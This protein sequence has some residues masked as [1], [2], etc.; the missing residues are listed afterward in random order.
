MPD[1]E[2]Y[3]ICFLLTDKILNFGAVSCAR[4]YNMK[5]NKDLTAI[6]KGYGI[7]FVALHNFLHLSLFAD[8]VQENE[9]TYDIQR[10]WDYL[11]VLRSFEWSDIGQFFSFLGWIGVA[12]FIF[13]SGYGLVKKYETTGEEFSIKN[14]VFHSW[15][16][17]AVLLFLPQLIYIIFSLYNGTWQAYIPQGILQQALL[18]NLFTPF[19]GVYPG[20][21][22]YFG[23]AFEMY[24]LYCVVRKCNV[25]QLFV[26]SL[27]MLLLQAVTVMIWGPVSGVWSWVRHNFIGWGQVFLAGMILAKS[28]SEKY[29]PGK[30]WVAWIIAALSLASLPFLLLNGWTWLLIVPY[31]ALLFFL[32]LTVAV[33]KTFVLKRVGLWL[34]KYSAFIFVT[35]PIVRTVMAHFYDRVTIPLWLSTLLYTICF[36]LGAIAYK[37]VYQWL[38]RRVPK[39]H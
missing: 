30:A 15:T 21:Y 28:D 3:E 7:L 22:W 18:A 10:T 13:L 33:S 27:V 12:V 31:V 38:M 11:A 2:I 9:N 4:Y 35:H 36:I 39:L 1:A 17:L 26:I 23:L 14:H 5:L 25:R 6:M 20:V 37:P 29:L 24:L 34:G 16:K 8:F 19:I 32:S